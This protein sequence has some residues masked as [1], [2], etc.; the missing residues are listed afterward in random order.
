MNARR[1]CHRWSRVRSRTET[2]KSSVFGIEVL[3]FRF[4]IF[5]APATAYFDVYSIS[6][7]TLSYSLLLVAVFIFPFTSF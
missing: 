1:S 5:T 2:N 6:S 3:S 4:M 7:D